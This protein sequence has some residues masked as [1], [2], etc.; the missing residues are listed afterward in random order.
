MAGRFLAGTVSMDQ[1]AILTKC[2]SL[3]TCT[4][5]A[6]KNYACV[7]IVWS[8][9]HAR[10]T[11]QVGGA[12]CACTYIVH[13]K[14]WWVWFGCP[15]SEINMYG[16]RSIRGM[17]CVRCREYRIV[18]YLDVPNVLFI[19]QVVCFSESPLLEISLQLFCSLILRLPHLENSAKDL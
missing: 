2:R 17:V 7:C 16:L 11:V 19:W 8:S 10:S 5:I 13:A 1:K 4:C 9:T 3:L 18:R 12:M 14:D 6:S 15:L